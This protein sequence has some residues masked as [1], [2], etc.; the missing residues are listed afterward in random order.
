MPSKKTILLLL[1]LLL[2]LLLI[3]YITSN[4]RKTPLTSS[5][6]L[7]TPVAFSPSPS[8]TLFTPT[9]VEE[10]LQQQTVADTNYTEA[11]NKILREYPWY[12]SLPLQA[13]NYFVLFD[14]D[15]KSFRA[16][17][18]PQKSSVTP[19]DNQVQNY[20]QEILE[21]L[22]QINIDMARYQIEWLIFPE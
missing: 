21:Q 3:L 16:R 7:P 8:P 19:I 13:E 14:L 12:N 10:E 17:I 9:T 5:P 20:K 15:K 4:F 11:Q 2:I 18:Y 22:Q 1:G 6:P